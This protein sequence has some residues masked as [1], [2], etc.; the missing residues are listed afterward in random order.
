MGHATPQELTLINS[1]RRCCFCFGLYGDLALKKG[2]IAHLDH[3]HQNDTLDNLA[4]LCFEHH[5]EYDSR[6]SQSKGLTIDEAKHYR[7]R[8]YVEIEKLRDNAS[9]KFQPLEQELNLPIV[10]GLSSFSRVSLLA[11]DR[12]SGQLYE[13]IPAY[14]VLDG[15][16]LTFD[17]TN[18]NTLDMRITRFYVDVV[19]YI[20]PDIIG[21]WSGLAGGGASYRELTCE[22][23]PARGRYEC[24]LQSSEYDYIRLTHREMEAFRINIDVPQEGIYWLKLVMEYSM[25][26]TIKTFSADTLIL[27]AGAFDPVL[28]A[29][30]EDWNRLDQLLNSVKGHSSAPPYQ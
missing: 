9:P 2:Q 12:Q 21:V 14:S 15:L 25:A 3:N 6:T 11:I 26:G 29:P 16:K 1:G 27:Q 7:E 19:Q 18:P 20:S 17:V 30:S 4:F 23:A 24:Q 22:I 13:Q 10:G 8:L 5:D 28:H